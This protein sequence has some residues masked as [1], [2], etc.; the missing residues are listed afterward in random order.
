MS[1]PQSYQ[2][3][4]RRPPDVEDY[5][6]ILRRYRS[7]VI[8]PTFAGLVLSVVVA[9]WLPNV[10]I[11]K[12]S[13]RIKPSAVSN[14]LL[15]SI[16]GQMSA[17]FVALEQ[18]ILGRDNLISLINMPSL[19]LYAK[20][21]QRYPVED[22]A[23]MYFRKNVGVK[24][25][26]S[27]SEGHGAQ[28]FQISFEYPDKVK[29][30]KVVAQLVNQ[31]QNKNEEFQLRQANTQN[32]LFDTLLKSATEKMEK[33]RSD[34]AN[35]SAE[36]QG[37]LPE[38]VQSNIIEVQTRTSQLMSVNN[39]VAQER[40]HKALLELELSNNQEAQG[41]VQTGM[42]QNQTVGNPT[43]RNTNLINLE[44]MIAAKK[45]NCIDLKHQYQDNYPKVTACNESVA[46]LERQRDEI[47]K[48]DGAVTSSGTKI[49]TVVVPNTEAVH[50]LDNLKTAERNL[51][52]QI[53]SSELA[54]EGKEANVKELQKLVKDAQDKVNASPAIIQ[55]FEDLQQALTM[56]QA[57]YEK[58]SH[59]K[60]VSDNTQSVEEH[61]AGEQLEVLEQPIQPETPASPVRGAIIGLG[62]LAGLVFGFVLA[63]AKEIKNTS[64]KNLKDVRA[65][66]NLP[67][68]SSIPLLENALLV[69]RKRRLAW[70]AWSSAVIIGGFLICSAIY[71]QA[72][73]APT[74][75]G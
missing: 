20:E 56:A 40:Q 27:D 58:Q 19:N 15:P 16:S 57:E 12:A 38:N 24:Q 7:W 71:Y 63:G 26:S 45:Q 35:F 1:A 9:C 55:K 65:Y 31:F 46:E 6:D 53:Q 5:I 22:V 32:N 43:V 21:R 59:N 18:E 30:Q 44:T 39:E 8:G 48:R 3:V 42:T 49:T 69:R 74:Q 51:R 52:A 41:H 60:E 64:L 2:S 62:T 23:E 29:A 61:Q 70:L 54:I 17:R 34:L 11:C 25:V 4:S 36:N 67:I 50:E 75:V 73:I 28:A 14:E 37:K 66:T 72:V 47:E 10:Y 13:L 68:L 33:A